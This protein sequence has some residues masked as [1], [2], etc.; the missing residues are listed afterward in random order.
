VAAAAAHLDAGLDKDGT[1]HAA[2]EHC[3]LCL[4]FDRLPAP[5]TPSV[6]PTA[7]FVFLAIVEAERLERLAL[8]DP[9]LWPPSRGPPLA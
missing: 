1:G 6:E 5:P 4:Q 2:N 8:D 9:Q 7:L 3:T